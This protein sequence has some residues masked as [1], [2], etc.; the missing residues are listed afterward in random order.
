MIFGADPAPIQIK[1]TDIGAPNVHLGTTAHAIVNLLIFAAGFAAVVFLVIG[2]I[3]YSLS[4]GD[5]KAVAG[6]KNTIVAAVIGLA[7]VVLAYA[8]L[9]Y[10]FDL[11]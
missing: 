8:I 3:R 4:R 5:E 11:L 7:V 2:G 10:V 9:K 6:A 1:N